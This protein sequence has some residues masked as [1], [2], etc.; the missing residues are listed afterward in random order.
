MR[1]KTRNN[2][3]QNVGLIINMLFQRADEFASRFIGNHQVP[4]E[5]YSIIRL[6][7]RILLL[8]ENCLGCLRFSKHQLE[9]YIIILDTSNNVNHPLLEKALQKLKNILNYQ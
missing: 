9:Q 5:H 1:I 6:I 4:Q 3:E 8:P 2:F 7:Y